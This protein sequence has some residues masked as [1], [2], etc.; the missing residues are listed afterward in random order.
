MCLVSC[1]KNKLWAGF[2]WQCMVCHLPANSSWG[3]ECLEAPY[4]FH[5]LRKA[6]LCL[7]WLHSMPVLEAWQGLA[8]W[9]RQTA[10]DA[11]EALSAVLSCPVCME[12]FTP[13]VL[14]LSCSH[15][16]CKQCL[17]LILV[18]Q[19]CTHVNGQFCCPVCRKVREAW[20]PS[21]ADIADFFLVNTSLNLCNKRA[22]VIWPAKWR[23]SGQNSHLWRVISRFLDNEMAIHSS[24]LAWR[25]PWTEEPG[26][27]LFMG[28][29]R[30]GHDWV[31]KHISGFWGE[32]A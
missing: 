4:A 27:L 8:I 12:L 15:N 18:C 32:Q 13:P 21:A 28:S 23:L 31:T 6:Q 29:Q 3:P 10:V 9:E 16:F 25:I 20:D 7:L 14:L 24:I 2:P 5:P 19:N 22:K 11:M 1:T 26:G 17:E 30:V